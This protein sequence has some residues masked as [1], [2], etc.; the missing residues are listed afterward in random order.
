M[1]VSDVNDHRIAVNQ[2]VRVSP[3]LH[4]HGRC[5]VHTAD[6]DVHEVYREFLERLLVAIIPA[7]G[8]EH[9]SY[10]HGKNNR[11]DEL[12]IT[13]LIAWGLKVHGDIRP[14]TPLDAGWEDE[15]SAV[16]RRGD[17]TTYTYYTVYPS[18]EEWL[19]EQ[20]RDFDQTHA[21]TEA[22]P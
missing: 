2:I 18:A 13:P 21:A 14:V 22:A 19:A 17:P 12:W 1:F 4:R 3:S 5:T 9:V 15:S 11:P 10:C 6:G 16:R 7:E 8:W 20:Q